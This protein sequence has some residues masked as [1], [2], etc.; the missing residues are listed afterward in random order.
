M[1]RLAG[2]GIAD[3]I[4]YLS[5]GV[6]LREGA[7]QQGSVQRGCPHPISLPDSG[8]LV[9]GHAVSARPSKHRPPGL[10]ALGPP[11]EPV[12]KDSRLEAGAA[13]DLLVCGL[14]VL[15]KLDSIRVET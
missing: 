13:A 11:Q 7:P 12:A 5:A 4:A 9:P 15:C 3:P 14:P 10:G 8:L 6:T 2:G 1:R